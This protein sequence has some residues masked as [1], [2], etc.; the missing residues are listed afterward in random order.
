MPVQKISLL[1]LSELKRHGCPDT[2]LYASIYDIMTLLNHS[3]TKQTEDYLSLENHS[4]NL[5]TN[6][7]F[8]SLF[9][10][11]TEK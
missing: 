4:L 1:K 3:T 6:R 11:D 9:N 10:E 8:S 2:P 7:F 5:E